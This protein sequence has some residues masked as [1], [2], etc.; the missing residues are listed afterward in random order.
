MNEQTNWYSLLEKPSWAPP[1]WVFGPVWT[2]L[3]C[4]I[5]VSFGY[6]FIKVFKGEL[7]FIV[8]LPFFLNLLFNGL[9]TPLQFGLQ[10]NTL[11]SIDILLV[12]GTLVWAMV[13]IYPYVPWVAIVNIP[14][15]FWVLFASGL[16]L[17]ILY[18]N[19]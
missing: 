6:V 9:F 8:G 19:W 13:A 4:I 14:Y 12:L 2:V 10:N 1:A 7:P 15:F 16:Q 18:L 5:F 17:T 11:A 3:Y